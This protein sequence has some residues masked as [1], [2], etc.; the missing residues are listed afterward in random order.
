MAGKQFNVGT[1]HNLVPGQC[2]VVRLDEESKEFYAEVKGTRFSSTSYGGLILRV[3]GVLEGFKKWTKV[4]RIELQN[5]TASADE[6]YLT[7]GP[8]LYS[9]KSE[10]LVYESPRKDSLPSHLKR[11]T[12]SPKEL[13]KLSAIH[14]LVDGNDKSSINSIYVPFTM[15]YDVLDTSIVYMS[16]IDL[17]RLVSCGNAHKATTEI[18]KAL[19]MVKQQKAELKALCDSWK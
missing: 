17:S 2:V 19:R 12:I 8:D 11:T 18:L 10:P 1:I 3:R 15:A 9:E 7:V 6:T 13:T 14:Y 4:V 16:D 5:R